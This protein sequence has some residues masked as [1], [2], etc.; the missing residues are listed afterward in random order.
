MAALWLIGMMGSGK[1]TVGALIAARARVPFVDLDAAIVAAAG[2][3]VPEIF[4]TEGEAGFRERETAALLEA[5][6]A[7]AVVACGGG[8]VLAEQNVRVMR[9]RGP[10][11]WLEADPAELAVRLG[12]GEGRPLLAGGELEARLRLI[13]AERAGAYAA[14]A[15]HRVGTGGREPG[16]I[17]EE[18]S[19][20]WRAWR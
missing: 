4:A 2:I 11:V 15:H 5:A 12:T 18:V 20:L 19:T 3:E 16:E 17:A 14:A 8:V 9:S 13:G 1:S 10:V 6:D 7:G